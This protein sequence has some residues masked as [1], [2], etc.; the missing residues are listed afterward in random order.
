MVVFKSAA[1][2]FLLFGVATKSAA[3][4]SC[5]TTQRGSQ[6]PDITDAW[7]QDNCLDGEGNLSSA[8][9]GELALC[10]C[11]TRS[12]PEEYAFTGIGTASTY[13]FSEG[14]TLPLLA[15]P[16]GFNH[17]APQTT[18]Q[19]GSRFFHM[20]DRTFHGIRCTH[21]PS[22]WIADYGHFLITPQ[23]SAIETGTNDRR[24]SGYD[25]RET[26][27]APYLFDTWLFRY[28]THVE[29]TS[30]SHAAAMRFTFPEYEPTEAHDQTRRVM[31]R[32]PSD[33]NTESSD[34]AVFDEA[35]Q[36]IT[37][38][39]TSNSNGIPENGDFG[40]Y[41]HVQSDQG[42]LRVD[43]IDQRTVSFEYSL[44]TTEVIIRTATS[45]IDQ[46]QAERNL[47][48][49]AGPERSFD[50][51]VQESKAE[52]NDLLSR[53]EIEDTGFDAGSSEE[54][55]SLELFY[56]NLYRSL[57]FPRH[58][59]E[60]AEDGSLY[61]YSPFDP[62]GGI[63]EG[64]LVTD[65]GFWDTHRTVY[66]LLSF[67]YP[68]KLG[69]ILQGWVNAYLEGGWLPKWASPGYRGCMVGTFADVV[70]GDAIV[71]GIEGFDM[72][73]A[74]EGMLKDSF[75]SND[76]SARGKVGLSYYEDL[77]Y[78]PVDA[79]GVGASVSRTMD[80]A[81]ADFAV[82]EAARVMG[83]EASASILEARAINYKSL[84]NPESN[85]MQPR[86]ENGTFEEGFDAKRWGG[87]YTE[88][89]AWH[90]SFPPFDA[91]GL[92]RMHG[93][94]DA[95]AAKLTE[96]MTTKETYR[97]GGYGIQIHE[98]V[99]MSMLHMG[100]YQ[101]GNQPVHHILYLFAAAAGDRHSTE[102]WVR[103][104]LTRAYSMTSYAG[105][106]DNGEMAAWYVFSSLGFYP[107]VPGKNEYVL[108]SPLF[109]SAKVHIPGASQPLE[110]RAPNNSPANVYVESVS[111]NGESVTGS[112][113]DYFEVMKGGVLKFSM[114][115]EIDV[116]SSHVASK[117][118]IE[119]EKVHLEV[120]KMRLQ[121]ELNALNK[122]LEA[123]NKE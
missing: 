83:D 15:R 54:T 90:H 4:L 121:E 75:E 27:F 84:Y 78:I 41:I 105:D 60:T 123:L 88:G 26:T 66:P 37:G 23:T 24:Y 112:I 93:G 1:Y 34:A 77:G 102:F 43:Q 122:E 97:T 108:G 95:L 55:E 115:S 22:P 6:F 20:N 56:S 119:R 100:M 33:H 79:E 47:L 94:E 114:K 118:E 19:L 42:V 106:E 99:E 36:A 73:A 96:F 39:T 63:H 45:F 69:I 71:K 85:L 89:S 117:A 18:D 58:F 120:E 16:W 101:H 40:M 29:L 113:L 82:A 57:L 49:E 46:D 59:H 12:P 38:K 48:L 92:A 87:P 61:H 62:E 107:M 14:N 35:R 9:D 68:D 64:V 51:L 74:Y 110:V 8:C 30:T 109:R 67:I 111:Y 65:N 31:V 80:F 44:N 2:V 86:L 70:L 81:F 7:C 103:E 11:S 50:E 76:D 72:Q 10:S 28:D 5:K 98:M 13:G 3:A 21:Q 116:H 91:E 52:W 32:L 53:V 104:A 25:P 17:W